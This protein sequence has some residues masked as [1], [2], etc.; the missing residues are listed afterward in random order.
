METLISCEEKSTS[1]PQRG[2]HARG[3]QLH[4]DVCGEELLT[5]PY[6]QHSLPL[7]GASRAPP[8]PAACK[9]DNSK[10]KNML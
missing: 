6:T 8:K 7:L 2:I 9:N 1:G 10:Q 3:K 5:L 4:G